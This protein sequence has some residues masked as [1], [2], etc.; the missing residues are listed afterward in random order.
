MLY[1]KLLEES[2]SLATVSSKGQ[3]TLPARVRQ[4]LGIRAKDKVRFVIAGDSI[5]VKP[6]RSFRRLRGSVNQRKGD[7]QKTARDA[8]ARHVL[9]LEG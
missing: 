1:T 3:I 5:V 7:P 9:G 4:A 2:M 6:V 8:V